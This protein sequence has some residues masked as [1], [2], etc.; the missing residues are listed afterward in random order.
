MTCEKCATECGF[1]RR[2]WDAKG[3]LAW[4]CGACWV[5]REPKTSAVR[6]V[7]FERKGKEDIAVTAH[8]NAVQRE[9]DAAESAQRKEWA[10]IAFPA[11]GSDVVAESD[12]GGGKAAENGND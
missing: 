1:L 7:E 11:T 10:A 6:V 2:A 8:L 5:P 12:G 4:L 3:G 9:Q